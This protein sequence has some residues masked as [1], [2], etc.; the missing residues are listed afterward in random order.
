M[1][2]WG[3]FTNSSMA[4]QTQSQSLDT[5]SQNIANINSPGFKRTNTHFVT[6]MSEVN[7]NNTIFSVRGIDSQQV[8]VAGPTQTTNN[9][10]DLAMNGPGLFIVNSQVN[11]QGTTEYTRN[12]SFTQEAVT[13]GNTTHNYLVDSSGNFLQGWQADASG[14]VNTSGPMTSI[15]SDNGSAVA[16]RATANATMRANITAG[17]A[18]PQSLPITIDSTTG[19]PTTLNLNFTPTGTNAWTLSPTVDGATV[20]SAAT[21]PV[22]FNGDG[23]LQTPAA[24]VPVAIQW[25]DGTT[26]QV[27][28]DLSQVTQYAAPKEIYSSSQ[29]GLAN[30]TV[31]DAR[32][33]SNGD[34]NIETSDGQSQKVFQLATADFANPNGLTALSGTMFSESQDSG[35]AQVTPLTAG[36]SIETGALE[37]SNVDLGNE[38]TRMITTQKAYTTAAQ[39][40]KTADTMTGTVRDLVT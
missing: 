25:A 27:N 37:Q 40:F 11:G 26:S 19:Q 3:A 33:Q 20:T 12:G 38:F 24:P 30:A 2:I 17:S 16:G 29:D 14:A 9:W 22:A 6:A 8:D 1:T 31:V 10:A 39:V 23:T 35:T 13:V 32:F 7:A 21:Q 15:Y 36:S 34:L 18:Q 28:V 5:I 4:M